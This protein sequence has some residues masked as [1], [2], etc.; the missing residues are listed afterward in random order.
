M[1]AYVVLEYQRTYSVEGNDNLGFHEAIGYLYDASFHRACAIQLL[2]SESWPLARRGW[3]ARGSRQHARRAIGAGPFQHQIWR[4]PGK[5][6][7][8]R[9]WDMSRV[10]KQG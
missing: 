7:A 4:H 3:R 2:A 1:I 8:G 6:A 9:G 10:P 5:A